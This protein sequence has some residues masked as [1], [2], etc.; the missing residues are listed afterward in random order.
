MESVEE[1]LKEAHD[2]LLKAQPDGAEH[3]TS[4]CGICAGPELEK[5]GE[6]TV[7]DNTFTEAEVEAKIAS[8]TAALEG[9]LKDEAAKNEEQAKT[10]ERIQGLEAQITEL[11]AK[12]DKADLEKTAESD[13]A[14][15]AEQEMVDTKAYLDSVKDEQAAAEAFQTLCD[16]RVAKVKEVAKFSD[17]HVNGS[18]ERWGRMVEADF[19]ALLSDYEIS[20]SKKEDKQEHKGAPATSVLETAR[21][22][23]KELNPLSYIGE[24]QTAGV[25]ASKFH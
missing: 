18:R 16:E 11:E 8:A 5:L 1:L 24:L 19:A 14:A 13:R 17:D 25:N 6:K 4:S 20:S 10:D 3:D 21:L 15:K 22:E 2:E 23:D 12:L 9:K 7:S